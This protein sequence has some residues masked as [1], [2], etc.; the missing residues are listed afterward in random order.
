MHIGA[1]KIGGE[2]EKKKEERTAAD[3][4]AT[5]LSSVTTR[6]DSRKDEQPHPPS[7]EQHEGKKRDVGTECKRE[8]E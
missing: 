3:R 6:A 1:S 2:G 8:K 4:R 5:L 7:R